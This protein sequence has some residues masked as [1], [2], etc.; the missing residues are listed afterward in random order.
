[1]ARKILFPED[2][3]L[4]LMDVVPKHYFNLHMGASI[5]NLQELAETLEIMDDA[6]FKHHVTKN[7]NDF[8]NWVRDVINDVDLSKDLL[9][10][11]NRK[12]AFEITKERIEQLN[13]LKKEYLIKEKLKFF[14][15]EFFIGLVLGLVLGFVISAIINSLI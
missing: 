6:T 5:R 10:A 3:K 8:S 14:N 13:E 1:M 4:I 2:A 12:K 11:K 15:N 7:K 9:K